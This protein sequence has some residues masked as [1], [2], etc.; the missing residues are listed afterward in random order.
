MPNGQSGG[1][2]IDRHE[3]AQ[4]LDALSSTS[5]VGISV[6]A[7]NRARS[8]GPPSTCLSKADMIELLVA[9][10][11]GRVW[12]EE[13]DHRFYVIHLDHPADKPG[14]PDG[15][16]W[17]LVGPDSQLF[18]VLRHQHERHCAKPRSLFWD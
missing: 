11:S 6:G 16:K 17:I 13:Q 7:V 5:T 12:I 1:F 18:E 8:I 4:L 2:L 10:P 9:F 15:D 14:P 3:F